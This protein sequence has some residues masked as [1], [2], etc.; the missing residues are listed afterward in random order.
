MARELHR[1]PFPAALQVGV[2]GLGIAAPLAIHTIQVAS[3]RESKQVSNLAAFLTLA[4]GL[5]LRAV[6]IFGG[7][8]A[9]RKPQHYFRV[10]QPDVSTRA[11]L[12]RGG[13][14]YGRR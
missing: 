3:G 5:L 12:E 8:A 6:F 9:A 14:A 7:N 2:I 4:G 1:Q 11:E 13:Q 10:T